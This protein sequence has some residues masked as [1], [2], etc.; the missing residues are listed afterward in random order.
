M[1]SILRIT[2]DE[3]TITPIDIRR[4][5]ATGAIDPDEPDTGNH[6]LDGLIIAVGGVAD[7]VQRFCAW[8]TVGEMRYA[9]QGHLHARSC[10]ID[11]ED[12]AERIERS[13]S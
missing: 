12:W 3:W 5:L 4:A 6:C 11:A 1:K 9:A 13:R 2:S 7:N 10:W 8:I